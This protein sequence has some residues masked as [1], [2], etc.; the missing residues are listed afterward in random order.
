MARFNVFDGSV[1]LRLVELESSWRSIRI[2]SIAGSAILLVCLFDW[3][4][5]DF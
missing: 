5:T 1:L 2:D 4:M 3:K